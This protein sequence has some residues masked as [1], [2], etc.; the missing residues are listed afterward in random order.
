MS[1]ERS[2]RFAARLM[3]WLLPRI[4]YYAEGFDRVRAWPFY[5]LWKLVG[6]LPSS[7]LYEPYQGPACTCDYCRGVPGAVYEP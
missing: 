5:M 4:G 3:W 6:L 1:P 2:N 7:A